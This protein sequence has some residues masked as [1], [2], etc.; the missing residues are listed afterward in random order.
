MAYQKF[1]QSKKINSVETTAAANKL[2]S[3]STC[4]T[5]GKRIDD[6]SW[7]GKRSMR[8]TISSAARREGRGPRVPEARE[9]GQ[10]RCRP[11]PTPA[12][13]RGHGTDSPQ[14]HATIFRGMVYFD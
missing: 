11:H 9:A 7:R 8:F 6:D 1:F 14:L 3:A 12:C 4:T 2:R 10:L 5:L 13:M